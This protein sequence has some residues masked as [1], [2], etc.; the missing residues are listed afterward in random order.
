MEVQ[1]NTAGKILPLLELMANLP[2]SSGEM[3]FYHSG[4]HLFPQHA[5]S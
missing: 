3:G 1:K 5:G 2:L 4:W